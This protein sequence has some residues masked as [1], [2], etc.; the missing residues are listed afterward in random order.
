MAR[1][2]LRRNVRGEYNYQFNWCN[3]KG[4]TI[5]FN[6]VW[7]SNKREAVKK[8][9]AMESKAHWAAW[10][11]EKRTYVEVPEFVSDNKHCFFNSGMYLHLPSM[12]KATD[13][14]AAMMNRIG[15][16]LTN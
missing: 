15:H 8:A 10:D 16:S 2:K 4:E 5:G 14:E 11:E 12:H 9:K 7:A 13:S 6:D 1:E 3:V